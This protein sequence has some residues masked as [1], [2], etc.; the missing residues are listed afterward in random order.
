MLGACV[1][2]NNSVVHMVGEGRSFS[3]PLISGQGTCSWNITGNPGEFIKLTFWSINGTCKQNYIKVFDVINS[4]RVFLEKF[5]NI[6]NDK[7][8][9]TVYS[10]SN[11]LMV[12]F[13]SLHSGV[14]F[15]TYESIKAVPAKYSGQITRKESERVEMKDFNGE[16]ASYN[17]PLFYSN[18]VKCLWKIERPFGHV[19]QLTFHSFDLQQSE[20]CKADYV[21]IEQRSYSGTPPIRKMRIPEGTF[22]GSS[23]PG[24][25]PVKDADMYVDFVSDSSGKYPGFHASY[26]IRRDR[27]LNGFSFLSCNNKCNVV[28]VNPYFPP[29]FCRET[30]S[31]DSMVPTLL[32]LKVFVN[33]L[34]GKTSPLRGNLKIQIYGGDRRNCSGTK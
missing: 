8:T 16:F 22:C 33:Y 18:D 1:L 2:E 21:K 32:L 14:F 28:Q 12:N 30:V 17:Y 3:S 24:I 34:H 15:A 6:N 9:R 13:T 31:S 29:H 10:Q 4:N 20:D 27:K 11:N 5:C 25:I 19:I 23:L 7:D 26:Q